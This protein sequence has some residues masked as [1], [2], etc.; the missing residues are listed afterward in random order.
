MS[1]NGISGLFS[2]AGRTVLV[3]GGAKGIGA[4]ITRCL[5]AAGCRVM[6]AGRDHAAADSLNNELAEY[7]G[8]EFIEC[9]LVR[10][11]H[12]ADLFRAVQARC[13]K[14]DALIN[15][16]GVFHAPPL[17]SVTE[18]DW[19]AVMSLN[20]QSPFLLIQ[21]LCPLLEKAGT[22]DDPARIINIGSVGG[23][24][25]KSFGGAYAYGCSKAAI[26]QLSRTLASD[27][28]SRNINVN[29]I[30]PGF[31]PSDLTAGV[32]ADAEVERAVLDG[33]PAHRFG[34]ATDIGGTAIYLISRASAYLTGTVIPLD[35]GLIVAP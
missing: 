6:V 3:T 9:D 19:S 32:I 13:S 29:A 27:L 12:L 28:R 11:D 21:A 33:I 34:S 10:D 20:L 30:A 24:L 31:F 4:M 22:A 26:H 35:G 18:K 23:I 14:L 1:W 25:G 2:V 16:A 17:G 8:F 7:G 5:V 15:N